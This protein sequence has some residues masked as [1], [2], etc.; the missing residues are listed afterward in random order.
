MGCLRG[1]VQR[2]TQQHAVQVTKQLIDSNGVPAE[3]KEANYLKQHVGIQR[4]EA[5]SLQENL[6][7][8]EQD[9]AAGCDDLEQAR[10]S[11]QE[12]EVRLLCSH[13]TGS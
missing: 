8:L 2:S 7:K 3:E 9:V 1:P 4:C 11:I 12:Q 10:L 5:E 13:F 6:S